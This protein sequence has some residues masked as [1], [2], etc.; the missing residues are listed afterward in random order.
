[1]VFVAAEVQLVEQ[2]VGTRP[3]RRATD[4]TTCAVAIRTL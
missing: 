1:M 3:L 4:V 2:C